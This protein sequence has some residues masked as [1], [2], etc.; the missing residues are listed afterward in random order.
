MHLEIAMHLETFDPQSVSTDF[1][2]EQGSAKALDFNP[3]HF[4]QSREKSSI[5]VPVRVPFPL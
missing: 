4:I 2:A 5:I 1:Q 3:G